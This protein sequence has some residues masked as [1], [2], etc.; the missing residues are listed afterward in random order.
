MTVLGLLLDDA[1]YGLDLIRAQLP[2]IEVRPLAG[3]AAWDA[4]AVAAAVRG[5]DAVV[6]GRKS[7]ALPPETIA[8]RGRLRLLAHCHGTVKHLVAKAHLEAGLAVSNWG[9]Q[10]AGVAE[11]ALCLLL[12]GLK[13]VRALDGHV[14]ADWTDD[15]RIHQDF[16]ASLIGRDVGLYGFG[17]IGRH[18]G[19]FLTALGAKVAIYDPYAKDIPAGIRVCASLRELFATCQCI[20]IHC[21]LND[22]TRHTVTAELLALLPQGAVVVNTAR[23]P[24]VVEQALADAC[25]AGRIVAGV[26]VIEDEKGWPRSPLAA[27][28]P[29]RVLLTGH[30]LGN[31]KGPDPTK[32]IPPRGLPDFV[33]ANVLALHAGRPLI[34]L[35]SAAQY[36]LKT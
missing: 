35:I 12:A 13:Q 5:C 8:D 33:V 36:D 34:N 2:G 28:S 25:A 9:D 16:P 14:R 18:M 4:A 32:P 21:G 27:V 23:G 29:D 7:P 19:R 20:S 17:P 26:D 15:R 3:C 31:G 1:V 24:V 11:S 22:G 6:T 10:V 30:I